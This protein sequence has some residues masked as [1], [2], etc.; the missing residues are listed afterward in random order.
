MNFQ[1]SIDCSILVTGALLFLDLTPQFFHFALDT[2]LPAV[3][4][5]NQPMLGYWLYMPSMSKPRSGKWPKV[6]ESDL[7]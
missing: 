4:E 1:A 3:Y 5:S 2:G 6:A 7:E